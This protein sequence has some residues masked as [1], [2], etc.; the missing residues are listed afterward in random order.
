MALT[1]RA[2]DAIFHGVARGRRLVWVGRE[3]R[4]AWWLTRLWPT[5]YERLMIRRTLG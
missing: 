3:A 5:A 1:W 4:L 2:G